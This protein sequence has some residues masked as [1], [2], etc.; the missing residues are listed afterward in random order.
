MIYNLKC[1]SFKI[2]TRLAGNLNF[3]MGLAEIKPNLKLQLKK[4]KLER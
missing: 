2:K 1:K 4:K 3:H